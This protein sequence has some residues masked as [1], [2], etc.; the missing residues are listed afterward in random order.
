MAKAFQHRQKDE[1][2]GTNLS[3]PTLANVAPAESSEVF[4]H[5]IRDSILIQ[6]AC[7]SV[8]S[9]NSKKHANL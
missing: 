9:T 8:T 5:L 6:T 7:A 2:G 3:M 4:V 1:R